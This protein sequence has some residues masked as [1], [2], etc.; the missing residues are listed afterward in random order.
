MVG[1]LCTCFYELGKAHGVKDTSDKYK[2]VIEE[3]S[4][5]KELL[6]TAYISRTQ[7]LT[8]EIDSLNDN[9]KPIE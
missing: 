1:M 7:E 4:N 3:M 2:C 5:D 8:N 9:P 6:L